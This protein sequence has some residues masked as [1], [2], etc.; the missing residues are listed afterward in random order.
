MSA[1][2]APALVLRDI[3]FR[4]RR[5]GDELFGGLSWSFAPGRVTAV[6]GE[7]GRGKSTLLY[8]LGLL[9]RPSAGEVVVDGHPVSRAADGTRSAV[10]GARI[11]FVFQD[12]ALDASR[13]VLDC[14]TEPAV[15]AG[16][17]RSDVRRRALD[18]LEMLGVAARAGHRP[19]EISGGQ[20][21]RVAIAR[22]LIND[23]AIVLADEPTGNLD[24][25]N[26]GAVLDVLAR[27]ARDGRTI[28]IATHDPAVVEA[29]DEVL[30]L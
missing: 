21:Q 24:R 18:L 20:A 23:P 5:G 25:T 29:A 10:R 28:V 1:G 15:Y 3:A 4:Y 16:A 12:A 14:V 17:R 11:G 9:L 27:T 22:A 6:T 19:G 8:V 2:P 13:T 7:S 30:T 26:S